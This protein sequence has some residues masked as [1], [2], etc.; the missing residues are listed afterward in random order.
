M[1]AFAEAMR[2][3]RPSVMCD[4]RVLWFRFVHHPLAGLHTSVAGAFELPRKLLAL[5]AEF[6]SM[7][8]AC[9]PLFATG[10][11]SDPNWT[12]STLWIPESHPRDRAHEIFIHLWK[13]RPRPDGLSSISL[14]WEGCAPSRPSASAGDRS[15]RKPPSENVP[16]DPSR[17]GWPFENL[18]LFT[19]ADF[20][21]LP[22][23][24]K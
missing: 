23:L 7:E 13:W 2:R 10:L 14:N 16:A 11:P 1:P 8:V 21:W 17:G 15:A 24:A 19:M 22:A 9:F 5:R 6:T 12:P 4:G 20:L 3:P 18:R